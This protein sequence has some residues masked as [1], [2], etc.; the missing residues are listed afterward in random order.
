MPRPSINLEPYKAEI[1]ELFRNNSSVA[2]LQ[3]FLSDRYGI[4]VTQQLQK[5]LEKGQIEGY[6]KEL[7]H[8]HF[9]S[10]GFMIA[11]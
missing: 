10:Q 1:I 5:E 2:T 6:G 4:K 9:R 7:L 11:R 8:R 3:E